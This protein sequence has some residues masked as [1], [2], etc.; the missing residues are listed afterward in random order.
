[1]HFNYRLL[2]YIRGC[3]TLN[4]AIQNPQMATT[5]SGIQTILADDRR[6]GRV[7]A[8]W[9]GP[10]LTAGLSMNQR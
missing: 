3:F 5:W 4:L 9:V 10:F 7:D 2:H 8:R 1:M 6:R